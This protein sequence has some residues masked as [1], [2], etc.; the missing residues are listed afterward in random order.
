VN[1]EYD[2]DGLDRLVEA[3]DYDPGTSGL[4][5]TRGYGFDA[6]TN[7]TSLMVTPAVGSPTTTTYQVASDGSD[8]LVSVDSG[9][10]QLQGDTQAVHLPLSFLAFCD[11]PAGMPQDVVE[12]VVFT[13]V[14]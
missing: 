11:T 4:V 14:G 3:R 6:A 5:E 2:Y 12:L 10:A 7:R 8:R 9:Q 1:R 13:R